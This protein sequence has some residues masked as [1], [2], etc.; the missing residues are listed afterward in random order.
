MK[1]ISVPVAFPFFHFK[2]FYARISEI[3]RYS[4][5]NEI[6]AVALKWICFQYVG[7]MYTVEKSPCESM[8]VAN[9]II[10]PVMVLVFLW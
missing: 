3:F 4:A 8:K 10:S 7:K 6:G 9:C 1:I 5:E 2:Y